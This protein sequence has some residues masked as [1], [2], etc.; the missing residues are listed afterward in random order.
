MVGND[1]WIGNGVK[2]LSGVTIGDGA[3]IAAGA[4]VVR[5]VEPYTTYGGVPAKKIKDRFSNVIK[6][7]LSKINWENI[8]LEKIKD[9]RIFDYQLSEKNVK[10]IVKRINEKY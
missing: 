5:N 7:E 2:I 9:L 6:K 8:Q 1:V 10:K 3:I 4:V